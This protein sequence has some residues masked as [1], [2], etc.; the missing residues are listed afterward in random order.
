ME[1][2]SYGASNY[3]VADS[4]VAESEHNVGSA[5]FLSFTCLWWCQRSQHRLQLLAP[6]R[7]PCSLNIHSIQLV[8][9]L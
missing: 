5:N 1:L 4:A 6:C 7:A 9:L 3:K 8:S 2:V